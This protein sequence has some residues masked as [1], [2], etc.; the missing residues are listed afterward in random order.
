MQAGAS[1]CALFAIAFAVALCK[2][3]DQH[4]S[5]SNQQLRRSHLMSVRMVTLPSSLRQ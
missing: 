2:G 3:D 5:S 1:D 4:K